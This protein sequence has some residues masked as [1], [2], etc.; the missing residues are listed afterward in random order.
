MHKH[1]GVKVINII[2]DHKFALAEEDCNLRLNS[3]V[4]T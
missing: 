1:Q 4:K 3:K 2:G